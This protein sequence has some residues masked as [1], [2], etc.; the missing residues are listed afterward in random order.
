MTEQEVNIVYERLKETCP[1]TTCWEP[2]HSLTSAPLSLWNTFMF[3]S[4][5]YRLYFFFIDFRPKCWQC[6][7]INKHKF[8]VDF[9]TNPSS[10]KHMNFFMIHYRI[11]LTWPETLWF[12]SSAVWPLSQGAGLTTQAHRKQPI[13]LHC[14]GAECPAEGSSVE[15]ADGANKQLLS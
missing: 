4:F 10:E 8:S 14:D 9:L 6:E 13:K 12:Y 5:S 3:K 7:T 1:R 2:Q 15:E 11:S